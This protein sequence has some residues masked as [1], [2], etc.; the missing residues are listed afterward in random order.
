MSIKIIKVDYIPE[1]IRYSPVFT[2]TDLALLAN[3]E[4]L[5]TTEEIAEF[6]MQMDLSAMHSDR[7]LHKLSHVY[8]QE[9]NVKDA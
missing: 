5:P 3:L 7:V 9:G 4:A 1:V 6:S 2:G 8:P